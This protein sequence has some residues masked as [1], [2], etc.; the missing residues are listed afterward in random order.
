METIKPEN[1]AHIFDKMHDDATKCESRIVRNLFH[2]VS[3]SKKYEQFV[4]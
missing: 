3:N 2:L 1:I 4:S